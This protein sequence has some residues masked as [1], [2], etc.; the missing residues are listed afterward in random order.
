MAQFQGIVSGCCPGEETI[1]PTHALPAAD[2][3]GLGGSAHSSS[4]TTPSCISGAGL[5]PVH[6][7]VMIFNPPPGAGVRDGV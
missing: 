2:P 1:L 5:L 3:R 4:H 7:A 6:H